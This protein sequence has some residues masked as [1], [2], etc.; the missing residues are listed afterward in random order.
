[1]KT[2]GGLKKSNEKP[3]RQASRN[4][5]AQTKNLQNIYNTIDASSSSF[6]PKNQACQSSS[7]FNSKK[8][9]I[10]TNKSSSPPQRMSKNNSLATF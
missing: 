1:L 8:P 9:S 3:R 6:V 4:R 5:I 10:A 2:L 7:H